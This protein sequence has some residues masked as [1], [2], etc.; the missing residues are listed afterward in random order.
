[1]AGAFDAEKM[2]LYE[3]GEILVL[4]KPAGLAVESAD[5][6]R[7]DLRSLLRTYQGGGMI[8]V[9]HRLDQP[10]EGVMVFAKTKRAAADLSAQAAGSG[11]EKI[12][13]ARVGG[14]IPGESGELRDVLVREKGRNRSSVRTGG[15]E[16]REARLTWKKT[17]E[18]LL[19]IRLG[20]G[21]HHQIRAQLAHAGMPIAGDRKYGGDTAS[22]LCLCASR[23]AF[24][25]PSDKRRMSFEMKPSFL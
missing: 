16:G 18:G 14:S 9:V 12:Y 2:I 19:E 6:I 8:Y 10:V 22:Q 1:M 3:D 4:Q 25:H 20:T 24:T 11:M 17:G 15:A 5:V 23:L 13:T 21:R 7:P